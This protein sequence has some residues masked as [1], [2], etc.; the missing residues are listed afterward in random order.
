MAILPSLTLV[1]L[2]TTP[3]I[4]YLRLFNTSLPTLSKISI[5][6]SIPRVEF[7]SR[8]ST[9]HVVEHEE[10][11][12][13]TIYPSRSCHPRYLRSFIEYRP[14]QIQRALWSQSCD[15]TAPRK[16]RIQARTCT[17]TDNLSPTSHQQT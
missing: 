11:L 15:F 16:W 8:V 5:S 17:A 3:H 7:L 1:W 10:S 12:E 2:A 9:Q 4:T 6:I 13:S 14:Q